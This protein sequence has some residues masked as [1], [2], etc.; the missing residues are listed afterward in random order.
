MKG[1]WVLA[2]LRFSF[3]KMLGEIQRHLRAEEGLEVKVFA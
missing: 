2:G 1:E 3:I